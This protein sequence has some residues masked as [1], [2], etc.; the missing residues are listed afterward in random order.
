MGEHYT[1]ALILAAGVGSRM[2]SS[3]TKQLMPLC[4]R[5]LLCYTLDTFARAACV[6]AV[7]VACRQ[8]EREAILNLIQG[9]EKPIFLVNGGQ[10]RAESARLAFSCIPTETDYVAIHDGARCLIDPDDI[11]RV[12]RV[13]HRDGAAT[14]VSP[15]FDTVKRNKAGRVVATLNR[16]EL[17]A[18]Q[19]PQVFSRKLYEQ[20]LQSC[21]LDSPTDDNALLESIG[22]FPTAV[23]LRYPNPKITTADDLSYA[24]YI[25]NKG[26]QKQYRVGYG[27]DVHRLVEGRPLIL[28]GVTIAHPRGLLGHSDA[29]VL[30]HAI[31]DALLGALALG[32]IG[33]HFPDTDAQYRGV[34]SL[35]LLSRVAEMIK[36]RG[37]SVVNV[38]ATLVMQSPKVSPYI[39]NMVENIASVL[40]IA[41][42][43]V[44][45]KATTEE[46]LGFTGRAE[47]IAAHAT[48]SV[49]V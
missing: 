35:V 24:E 43:A 2:H 28:G 42:N 5:P 16:E 49:L 48:A 25:V 22:V 18:A 47:G 33:R 34:S 1:T 7:V 8:E 39:I 6:D 32:D 45:V 12:V 3:L 27:Y 15:I 20:A 13:A 10:S 17:C 41:P 14:A 38:D 11:D 23:E 9:Y 37:A 21:T 30:V 36:E 26:R 29:D 19:T 44:N 40:E 4:D 46:G 31:M